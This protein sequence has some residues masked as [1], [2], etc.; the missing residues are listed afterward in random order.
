MADATLNTDLSRRTILA[1]AAGA[2]ALTLPPV[3]AAR[4]SAPQTLALAETPPFELPPSGSLP[5][6]SPDD[7]ALLRR[8][9]AAER[10]WAAA[11]RA[12]AHC[13]ALCPS[14]GQGCTRSRR[15]KSRRSESRRAYRAA[16]AA[17]RRASAAFETAC[18]AAFDGPA[19]SLRGLHARMALALRLTREYDIL[20]HP[21]Y[22]WLETA[23][24]EL[25]R[26][27]GAAGAPPGENAPNAA[28]PSCAI[29]PCSAS[30]RSVWEAR[31]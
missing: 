17:C 29:P 4:G 5:L 9:A 19:R 28:M 12:D 1:V 26:I 30:L 23:L 7:A 2:G 6:S 11:G 22:D 16:R 20:D 25:A 13:K 10:A 15:P 18:A 8:V 24:A 27:A 3:A 21:P 14:S 31:P